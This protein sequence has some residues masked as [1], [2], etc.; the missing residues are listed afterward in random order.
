MLVLHPGLFHVERFS[1]GFS[2]AESPARSG[3]AGKRPGGSQRPPPRRSPPGTL[4]ALRLT[5]SP[6]LPTH[7]CACREAHPGCGR[8]LE[9]ILGSRRLCPPVRCRWRRVFLFASSFA[10]PT[11]AVSQR[12]RLVS[13][14]PPGLAGGWSAQL[15]ARISCRSPVRFGWIFRRLSPASLS[16]GFRS[17]SRPRA[18]PFAEIRAWW[19]LLCRDPSGFVMVACRSCRWLIGPTPG[20][21]LVAS[22]GETWGDLQEASSCVA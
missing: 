3:W 15:Q 11:V 21:D 12:L 22:T 18:R 7:G 10:A 8:P 4:W 14:L 17:H 5:R 20:K 2:R 19:R 1:Q 9:S 16:Q 6:P 13:W